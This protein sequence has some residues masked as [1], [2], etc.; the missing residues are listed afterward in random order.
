M[1]LS[2]QEQLRRQKRQELM[3]MGIDP[4]PAAEYPVNVH[5]AEILANYTPDKGN[6]QEVVLAGR[7][8]GFLGDDFIPVKENNALLAV[9]TW[10]SAPLS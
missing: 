10:N 9:I 8:M 4:Y 5:S 1:I 6:Y 2:E 3:S 7:L